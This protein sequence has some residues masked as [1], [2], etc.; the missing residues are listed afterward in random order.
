M[1]LR[2]PTGSDEHGDHGPWIDEVA[3]AIES[4]QAAELGERL[5]NDA[6]VPASLYD[7]LHQTIRAINSVADHLRDDD[8]SNRVRVL[9]IGLAGYARPRK[10]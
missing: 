1:I 5:P 6:P 10:E 8:S 2:N 7:A 9:G 4:L 3:Q